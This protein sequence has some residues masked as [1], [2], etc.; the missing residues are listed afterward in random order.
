[1]YLCTKTKRCSCSVHCYVSA[2]YNC[3]FF[4]VENRSIVIFTECFHK[5][6]SCQILI[7]REYTICLLSRNSHKHRKA[8]TGTDK[9]SLKAFFFQKLI[10]SYGFSNNNICFNFNAK[11]F[12]IF[13]FFCNNLVLWKTEFRNSIYKNAACFVKCLKN[14]HI[15]SHFCKVAR[16]GKTSRT[17][18]DDCD[19]MTIFLFCRSWFDSVLFCP[20]CNK[21]LQLTDRNRLTLDAA[22]TFSL[23]LTFLRTYTSTYCRKCAGFADHLISCFHISFFYFM[24]KCR[25]INGN[26]AALYTFCIFTV[27]AACCFFHCFFFVISKTNFFKVLCTNFRSLFSYWYFL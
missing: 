7:G 23:A 14:C 11:R 20:V 19:F 5:I 12:Y 17:G 10:D 25:N 21:T 27:N 26:R 15:I 4:A 16:T 9:Y 3:N 18:T 6:I 2:T 24:D 8:G 22:D 1:M 13:Y